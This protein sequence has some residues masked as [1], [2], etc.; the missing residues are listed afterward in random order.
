MSVVRIREMCRGC[1]VT[2]RTAKTRFDCNR[3]EHWVNRGKNSGWWCG[4]VEKVKI[5]PT[6]KTLLTIKEDME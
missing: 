1:G 3:K 5:C 2:I 6:C 4:P